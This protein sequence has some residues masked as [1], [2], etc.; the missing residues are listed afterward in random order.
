[1]WFGLLGQAAGGE[2]LV[3]AEVDYGRLAVAGVGVGVWGCAGTVV[4]RG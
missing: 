4:R 3:V 2:E 1:M